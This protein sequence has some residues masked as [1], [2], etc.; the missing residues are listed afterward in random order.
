M[1]A[2]EKALVNVGQQVLS[3]AGYT[4]AT[5]TS[6]ERAPVLLKPAPDAVDPALTDMTMPRMTGEQLARAIH[7]IRAAL[8]ITNCS[9]DQRI[10]DAE[11]SRSA[12]F[13][14]AVKKSLIMEALLRVVGEALQGAAAKAQS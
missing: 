3:H 5:H 10:T 7:R 14:A 13:V 11:W 2:D 12:E 9:G 8:P 4:V 1:I 6:P